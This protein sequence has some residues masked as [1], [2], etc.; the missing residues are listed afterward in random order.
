MESFHGCRPYPVHTF[1]AE[2][3]TSLRAIFVF[4]CFRWYLPRLNGLY[5]PPRFFAPAW[6]LRLCFTVRI[7]TRPRGAPL[8]PKPVERPSVITP[9]WGYPLAPTPLTRQSIIKRP[10]GAPLVSKYSS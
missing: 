9:L 7:V 8:T 3:V 10:R 2:A 5:G 6:Y 1:R 4:A